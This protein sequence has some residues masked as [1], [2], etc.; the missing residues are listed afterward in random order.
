MQEEEL[1]VEKLGEAMK[2]YCNKCIDNIST[3]LCMVIEYLQLK[4]EENS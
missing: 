2:F 4:R 1:M 3:K